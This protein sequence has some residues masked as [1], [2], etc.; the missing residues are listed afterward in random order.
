MLTDQPLHKGLEKRL[1]A[2]SSCRRLPHHCHF[3]E[4]AS[5][6]RH[7]AYGRWALQLTGQGFLGLQQACRFAAFEQN[8]VAPSTFASHLNQFNYQC[9]TFCTGPS[10]DQH[11]DSYEIAIALGSAIIRT[12]STG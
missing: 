12:M 1:V 9:S 7:Q 10:C 8:R 4:A 2:F 6:L 5:H 3:Y 11:F